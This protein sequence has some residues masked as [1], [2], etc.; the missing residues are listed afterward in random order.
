MFYFSYKN[1]ILRVRIAPF[2]FSFQVSTKDEIG[3][4]CFSMCKF[5]HSRKLFLCSYSYYHLFATIKG[6]KLV[7]RIPFKKQVKGIFCEKYCSKQKCLN[8]IKSPK[9]MQNGEIN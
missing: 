4:N 1:K 3:I 7:V 5:T 8:S 6:I 2:C 9:N